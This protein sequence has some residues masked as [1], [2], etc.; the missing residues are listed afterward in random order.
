[1]A[2]SSSIPA[3]SSLPRATDRHRERLR[4]LLAVIMMA[5]GI[6]HFAAA[7][8][9]VRMVPSWLPAPLA[10]VLVSGVFEA[11]GG[12]GLLVAR[13]RRPA[14]IGLVL[15]FLAV[16][17]ANINMALHPDLFGISAWALW[18]RLPLQ[19]LLI[20]WALWAGGDG[21]THRPSVSR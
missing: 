15:L 7:G 8:P 6:L 19:A 1:M 13:V 11:L 10:L 2:V 12:A 21:A 14:S 9:F 4:L 3:E 5:M 20:A 18:A 17:P 16:F